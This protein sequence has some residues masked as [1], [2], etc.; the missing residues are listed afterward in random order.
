MYYKENPL[1]L[2]KTFQVMQ[3]YFKTQYGKVRKYLFS[4][5]IKLLLKLIFHK[6]KNKEISSSLII[7]LKALIKQGYQHPKASLVVSLDKIPE[8]LNPLK[9]EKGKVVFCPYF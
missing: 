7:K 2:F 4:S 8:H 6:K 5:N 1:S 9:F 3:I